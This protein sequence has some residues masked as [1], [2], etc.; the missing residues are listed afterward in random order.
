MKNVS[1]NVFLNAIVCPSLWWL[2]R[3]GEPIEQ[4]SEESLSLVE[5]FCIEQGV[6]IGN[7]ARGLYPEGTLVSRKGLSMAAKE[8]LNLMLNF[9][10]KGL[11]PITCLL[12]GI[13]IALSK[14]C[15]SYVM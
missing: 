12:F 6:E 3:S 11:L 4:L 10:D 1:K 5:R 2:L 14:Y 9:L 7:R 8:T 15:L 13:I